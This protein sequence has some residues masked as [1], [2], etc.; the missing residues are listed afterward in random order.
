MQGL[1]V[2]GLGAAAQV[3]EHNVCNAGT[4]CRRGAAEAA[5]W[6]NN[7]KYDDTCIFCTMA[8]C[9]TLEERPKEREQS[10]LDKAL[11]SLGLGF[12]VFT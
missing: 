6:Q 8:S 3:L 12:M 2:S 1:S 5:V 4:E 7:E 10:F 9:A 11:V